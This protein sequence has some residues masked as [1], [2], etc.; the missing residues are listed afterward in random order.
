MNA[1]EQLK[2]IRKIKDLTQRELA[3]HLEINASTVANIEAAIGK[4]QRDIPK[5]MMRAL[6]E[7]MN[8]NA[9]WLLTGQGPMFL[10]DKDEERA[11]TG[12][13]IPVLKQKAFS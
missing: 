5:S 9:H 3:E 7:K 12:Y 1:A 13:R 4:T 6:V 8:V 2:A 11:V 10:D